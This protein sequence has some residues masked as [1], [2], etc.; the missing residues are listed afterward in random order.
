LFPALF[1]SAHLAFASRAYPDMAATCGVSPM[2][3]NVFA[4]NA[5]ASPWFPSEQVNAGSY[6][7]QSYMQTNPGSH[8]ACW[9][10]VQ[11]YGQNVSNCSG[12]S[13]LPFTNA[14]A[15]NQG[16]GLSFINQ[17]KI[18]QCRQT[19]SWDD[20][21]WTGPEHIGFAASRTAGKRSE[22][23][24]ELQDH[25]LSS[26][27]CGSTS[28]SQVSAV[29]SEV[30]T[31]GNVPIDDLT[32]IPADLFADML[33]AGQE[34]RARGQHRY[35]P[36]GSGR[37]RKLQRKDISDAKAA[38]AAARSSTRARMPCPSFPPPPAPPVVSKSHV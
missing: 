16:Y 19:G 22:V 10:P 1:S 6:G 27:T 12:S 15:H 3:S 32:M 28:S 14:H 37:A 4:L 24:S 13:S 18:G 8:W 29:D 35:C 26:T 17:D 36:G 38:K 21:P 2:E 31:A 23:S 20:S 25:E 5:H 33:R 30:S 11:F 34:A 7:C 9:V